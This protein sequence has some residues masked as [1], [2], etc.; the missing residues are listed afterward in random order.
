VAPWGEEIGVDLGTAHTQVCVKG[1]G[2]VVREPSVIAYADGKRRPIAIGE[3]AALL[4]AK[5]LPGVRVVW[6]LDGGVVA[7]FDAAVDLARQCVRAALGRRPLVSPLVIGA[8]T[9]ETTPVERRALVDCLRHAGGGKVYLVPKSLAAGLGSEV[10]VDDTE[11]R[12][13]MDIGAGTTDV[14]LVSMGMVTK[15]MSL[16][17]AGNDLDEVLVRWVKR[18][19]GVLITH[20]TAEQ[21]KLRVSAVDEDLARKTGRLSDLAGNDGHVLGES[22][23]LHEVPGVL[24]RAVR[25]IVGELR[26]L[27]SNLSPELAS[28]LRRGGMILTGG[29]VLLR[30]LAPLMEEAAG[31]QA[32]V[33]RDPLSCTILGLETIL[34]NL[35][36]LH[37]RVLRYTDILT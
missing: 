12:L 4:E 20:A 31:T 1:E 9:T 21:I 32:T 17:Y 24:R 29:T 6:P 33:A 8:T 27:L 18:R 25:P 36:A 22:L 30:G 13:V 19:L 15:A 3:E 34:T 35:R 11:T 10:P 14:G 7:D 28:E 37:S 26:W 2:I 5:K 16:H 23:P